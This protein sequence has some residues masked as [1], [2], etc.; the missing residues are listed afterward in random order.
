MPA[1]I[2]A[3]SWWINESCSRT[4][5]KSL[6]CFQ[7][8]NPSCV[9]RDLATSISLDK[10]Q[11]T[12]PF[13]GEKHI[14]YLIIFILKIR[15]RHTKENRLW[16]DLNHVQLAMKGSHLK[17]IYFY[18]L[19]LQKRVHRTDMHRIHN[20]HQYN[21]YIKQ[22]APYIKINGMTSSKNVLCI[23]LKYNKS[24]IY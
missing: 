5:S 1:G 21:I 10:I 4:G 16:N 14:S 9:N 20:I 22:S 12:L 8:Q 17:N 19:S 6:A 13:D 3:N 2:I 18:I 15:F 7:S 23:K 24:Q 11:W